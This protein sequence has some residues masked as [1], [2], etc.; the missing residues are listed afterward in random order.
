MPPPRPRGPSAPEPDPISKALSHPTLGALLARP[1][2]IVAGQ[3]GITGL[4]CDGRQSIWAAYDIEASLQ[5][6]AAL[7]AAI[8]FSTLDGTRPAVELRWLDGIPEDAA[9]SARTL[10]EQGQSCFS[11]RA[12]IQCAKEAIEF[13]RDATDLPISD[14]AAAM[15][16]CDSRR[17]RSAAAPGWIAGDRRCRT[18]IAKNDH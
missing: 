6:M 13:G 4:D 16:H 5:K 8:D 18:R 14:F 1:R 2:T 3:L 7:H 12:L 9:C 17:T 15:R 11:A 10:V